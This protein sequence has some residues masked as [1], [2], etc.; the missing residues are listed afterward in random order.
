[1]YAKVFILGHDACGLRQRSR[2]IKILSEIDGWSRKPLPQ[3]VFFA[4]ARDGQAL[5]GTDVDAGVALDATRGREVGLDVAIETAL[6]FPRGLFSGKTQLHFDI[7]PLE[8]LY[9]VDVA[10]LLP[11]SRIVIVVITPLA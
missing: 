6:H 2:D 11:R 10:H 9:Q 3:I 5:H 7:H 4:I 8:A 1:M